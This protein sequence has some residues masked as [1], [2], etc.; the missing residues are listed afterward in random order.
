MEKPIAS[1]ERVFAG[2]TREDHR[3][4]L[5]GR[6]RIEAE[7]FRP[8]TITQV[9]D[10]VRLEYDSPKAATFRNDLDCA[11]VTRKAVVR[12]LGVPV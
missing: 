4:Y 11:E 1:S 8:L 3:E 2:M 5:V 12:S 10:I 6:E 9:G 7:P